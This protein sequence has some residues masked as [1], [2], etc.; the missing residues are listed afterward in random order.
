MNKITCNHCGKGFATGDALRMH[1]NAKHRDRNHKQSQE[2]RGFRKM[3]GWLLPATGVM[4]IAGILIYLLISISPNTKVMPPTDIR[5][6]VEEN[7]PSHVMRTPMA[8]AVQKHMLEHSDGE[9]RPGVI[10]NYNCAD[11]QCEP[12]LIEKLEAF[13]YNYSHVYVA[14]FPNMGARIVLTRLGRMEVLDSYDSKKI[15]EFIQS[16]S[17]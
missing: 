12:D 8:V 2:K 3:P 17:G 14:P 13:A 15:E 16:A 11:F 5:N 9:G 10:I 4:G 7:P 6:H 1:T